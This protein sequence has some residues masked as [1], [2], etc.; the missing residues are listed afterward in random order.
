MTV[1]SLNRLRLSKRGC[2]TLSALGQEAGSEMHPGWLEC[3]LS[4]APII[5]LGIHSLPWFPPGWFLC[6]PAQSPMNRTCP[7]SGHNYQDHVYTD[8]YN[9]DTIQVSDDC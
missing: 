4:L 8:H 5:R 2:R 3:R 7:G 6:S 9:V 1:A